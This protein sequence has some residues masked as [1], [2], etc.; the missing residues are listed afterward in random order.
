MKWPG[1]SAVRGKRTPAL[2][3]ALV[4][5]LALAGL[6]FAWS[7]LYNVAATAG[8]WP[9]TA[10]LLHYTMR[11]S[12]ETH[13]LAIAAPPLDDVA[14]VERG[15]GHYETGCAPCHGAPGAPG[16]D[17]P[18]NMLPE[19]PS[20]PPVVGKWTAEELFWIVRHGLKY[21]GM[22]AWPAPDREDEVWA[23]TAFLIELP[24]MTPDEY[25]ALATGAAAPAADMPGTPG[26]LFGIAEATLI[27]AC[28][29]CHGIDG[30]GRPSG[31]FPRLDIQSADYLYRALEE[32]ASGLRPSGI[33]QPLAATL[34][35]DE[36][37]RLTRH[38]AK[39]DHS[40]AT[41]AAEQDGAVVELGRKIAA[42]GIPE[43]Q[44]APC[45]AC[46]GLDEGPQNSLF[47]TLA[48]QH[49]AFTI[50]QLR[51]FKEGSRGGGAF[52]EIMG[53]IAANMTAEEMQAVARFYQD[54][55]AAPRISP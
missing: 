37:E 51:L 40:G 15:A 16:N 19:P 35:P 30:A 17:V 33:M 7:G 28:A 41:P 26:E 21:T 10:W 5:F 25:V 11:N 20:L 31:A 48:G 9:I 4:V 1:R 43:R 53:P 44:I 49:S 18:R 2:F 13:A 34:D 47:P 50:L 8:H 46:H 29:R 55:P 39:A 38:Y 24:G 54:L 42:Q 23:V 32:Y 52:A 12:V 22:P 45:S 14:L 3:I 36:M 6:L 27:G